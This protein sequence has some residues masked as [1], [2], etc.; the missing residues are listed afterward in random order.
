MSKNIAT[1]ALVGA[2]TLA[3]SIPTA[4]AERRHRG[5]DHF[6]GGNHYSQSHHR[7]HRGRGHYVNGKWIALGI[8]GAVAAG[9]LNDDR[10]CYRRRGRTYCN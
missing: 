1:M 10:D 2:L 6:K 4:Q 8:L 5:G 3:T 7:G 9:A